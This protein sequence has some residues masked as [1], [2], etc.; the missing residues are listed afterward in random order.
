MQRERMMSQ[1]REFLRPVACPCGWEG[2]KDRVMDGDSGECDID[3]CESL[4]Q[5][6]LEYYMYCHRPVLP[7]GFHA[8]LPLFVCDFAGH[9]NSTAAADLP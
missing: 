9:I 3:V 7:S 1:N 8:M 6:E 2:C 5:I 4:R